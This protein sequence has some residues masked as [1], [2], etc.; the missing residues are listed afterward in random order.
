[1]SENNNQLK[2]TYTIEVFG[3]SADR[4]EIW[5][6]TDV[7]QLELERAMYKGLRDMAARESVNFSES[8]RYRAE[9]ARQM[10]EWSA[11]YNELRARVA[12]IHHNKMD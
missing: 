1:M 7:E 10:E 2:W 9:A 4:L 8:P 6:H 11:C 5:N 12:T 3:P